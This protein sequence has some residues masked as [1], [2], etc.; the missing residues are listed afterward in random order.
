MM[1]WANPSVRGAI[2]LG[3]TAAFGFAGG[4]GAK[5]ATAAEVGLANRFIPGVTQHSLFRYAKPFITAGTGLF[6]VPAVAGMLGAGPESKKAIRYG[7]LFF[8]AADLFDAVIGEGTT[9]SLENRVQQL[10]EGSSV[11]GDNSSVKTTASTA[12][13]A[14]AAQGAATEAIKSGL[15]QDDA[16]VVAQKAYEGA[17][18]GLGSLAGIP[19]MSDVDVEYG[20]PEW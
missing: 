3:K 12:I 18:A 14:G 20:G 16:A 13:A 4:V 15:S 2:G 8:A 7:G 17:Q 9:A 19:S 6:P 11:G 1:R 5:V 10:L